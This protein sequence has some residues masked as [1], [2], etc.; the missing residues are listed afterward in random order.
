VRTDSLL[1]GRLTLADRS[2]AR[3]LAESDIA[4]LTSPSSLLFTVEKPNIFLDP[5][6]V[7]SALSS[8]ATSASSS[9]RD[10]LAQLEEAIKAGKALE[11]GP[12]GRGG[13]ELVQKWEGVLKQ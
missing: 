1:S 2:L 11:E 13:N 4:L 5:L 3:K 8:S 12:L 6:L 7:P 9:H 10:Q